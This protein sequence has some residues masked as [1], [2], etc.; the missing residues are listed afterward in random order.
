MGITNDAT[1]A[2]TGNGY[3]KISDQSLDKL[4]KELMADSDSE[5]SEDEYCQ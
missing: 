2:A 5:M 4:D 1:S 3:D